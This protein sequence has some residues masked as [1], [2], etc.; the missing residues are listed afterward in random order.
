VSSRIVT[1]LVVA[2]IEGAAA[3]IS[4]HLKQISRRHLDR[5]GPLAD[6]LDF[7]YDAD[8]E[9]YT[10]ADQPIGFD[11]SRVSKIFYD[12]FRKRGVEGELGAV[13]AA[14][15]D[16][17]LFSLGPAGST[18]EKSRDKRR[19]TRASALLQQSMKEARRTRSRA[20]ATT[21][22]EFDGV[23][24]IPSPLWITAQLL[25]DPNDQPSRTYASSALVQLLLELLASPE[26]GGKRKQHL[27]H[28]EF[29]YKSFSA[30]LDVINN[31]TKTSKPIVANRSANGAPLMFVC[32]L[33]A[34]QGQ[35]AIRIGLDPAS[36]SEFES[37]CL[38]V[39][40]GG[41]S[42]HRCSFWS[43]PLLVEFPEPGDILNLT[44]SL[45][46]PIEGADVIFAG[47]L[48]YSRDASLVAA[49]SGPFGA[50]KTSISLSLAAA[51]APLGCRTL[52]LSCEEGS[53]DA[54]QRLLEA[55]PDAVERGLQ[56]FKKIKPAELFSRDGIREWFEASELRPLAPESSES[57][58]TDSPDPAPAL[59]RLLKALLEEAEL[60][61]PF[62][63]TA[64]DEGPRLPTCARPLII[65]DGLHQLFDDDPLSWD[66][67]RSLQDLVEV[68][69][70]SGAVVLFTIA[71]HS[72]LLRRLDFLCDLVIEL[73]REGF[74]RRGDE[75]TRVFRL[76]KARH[77]PA[78]CGAHVFNIH[79]PKGFRLKPNLGSRTD[80]SKRR[81]WQPLDDRRTIYLTDQPPAG[82]R[83]HKP[84]SKK[85]DGQATI[86]SGSQILVVGKGS[87]G[88]AGFALYL[89]HR[90]PFDL[91]AMSWRF[92]KPNQL[93]LIRSEPIPYA[94]K[95]DAYRASG[96]PIRVDS[97]HFESRVL[98]LSFLYPP[99]YYSRLSSRLAL[100]SSTRRPGRTYLGDDMPPIQEF[101]AQ[102]DR[103]RT[104]TISLYPGKLGV[105]NLLAKIE[106]RLT[107]AEYRGLP[108]TGVLLDGLHN[109]FVQYPMLER[110][111]GFWP[112][113]YSLLRR[114]HLT[115]VTTHTKFDLRDPYHGVR[116]PTGGSVNTGN[117]DPGTEDFDPSILD[118]ILDLDFEQAQRK[119]A[120][121]MSAL[122][123]ASD[124][125]FDLSVARAGDRFGSRLALISGLGLD[126]SRASYAWDR[127]KL[128]IA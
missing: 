27:D 72:H 73:D 76:L 10:H 118:G 30:A 112:E 64:N 71:D 25:T 68:C 39:L 46:L 96:L 104:E 63:V 99:E 87:S 65:I 9:D 127:Q 121:L 4:W 5:L 115:V 67:E 17:G 124:Y 14:D 109:V 3:A 55:A 37:N 90:R 15:E 66:V 89:L 113:L 8:L 22:G 69:R 61:A 13:A 88:K 44:N 16:R 108:F 82:F 74:E 84:A 128:A 94:T 51:L 47:G 75:P 18:S 106:E 117:Y 53:A 43:D 6:A 60:F 57:V 81:S 122:V 98:V 107:S 1:D 111:S 80:A 123:S 7:G 24:S 33:L 11:H 26:R 35:M 83:G 86:I 97:G 29:D 62:H 23:V 85:H 2:A 42:T 92:T 101:S 40:L 54:E 12:H 110:D 28:E 34:L 56:L 120:P 79:G 119:A 91:E 19:K 59:G 45:P 126:Y 48:R 100:G 52:F 114:R 31:R 58:K 21:K 78:R 50:G 93:E 41:K 77:Q 116:R 125:V 38:D 95:L 20:H 70:S 103:S 36:L 32:N 105:E 102:P 49:I